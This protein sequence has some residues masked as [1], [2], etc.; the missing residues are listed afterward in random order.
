MVGNVTKRGRLIF[1]YDT[2]D[3]SIFKKCN[4]A[5]NILC[6]IMNIIIARQKIFS[7][8]IYLPF[9][10]IVRVIFKAAQIYIKMRY[11]Y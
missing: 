2:N 3:F 7:L 8:S 11:F 1:I 4:I 10:G 6:F 9:S 5:R